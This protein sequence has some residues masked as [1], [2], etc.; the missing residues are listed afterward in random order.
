MFCRVCRIVGGDM[1]LEVLIAEKWG[2]P[3]DFEGVEV[4][5]SARCIRRVG[6]RCGVV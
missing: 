5:N 6:G 1:V 4:I 3:D 2:W